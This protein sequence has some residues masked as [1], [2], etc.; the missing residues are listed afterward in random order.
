MAAEI[1]EQFLI[2]DGAR[3]VEEHRFDPT[4][5]QISYTV[6]VEFP[7]LAVDEPQWE[8]LENAGWAK[9]QDRTS[10]WDSYLDVSETPTRVIHQHAS[11]WIKGN[12]IITVVLRYYSSAPG[13]TLVMMPDNTNQRVFLLFDEDVKGHDTIR[14]LDLKCP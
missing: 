6:D 5:W 8:Q 3:N 14:S 4:Y 13:D 1:P 11:E 12:R 9:C 10:N 2:V 7:W